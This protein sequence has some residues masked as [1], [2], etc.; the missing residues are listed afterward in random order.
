MGKLIAIALIII[1]LVFTGKGYYNYKIRKQQAIEREQA[2]AA[3]KA[4][5]EKILLEK[6]AKKEKIIAAAKKELESKLRDPLATNYRNIHVNKDNSGVCGEFNAKNGF[7]GY[8]GFRWF[9]YSFGDINLE[10]EKDGNLTP[11]RVE[12]F[13][14][15]MAG[16]CYDIE[17]KQ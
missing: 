10:P 5:N 17:S 8:T 1:A 4:A 3:E 9:V 16:N 13:L 11:T 2:A 12:N 15:L 6:Q 14:N 7:G